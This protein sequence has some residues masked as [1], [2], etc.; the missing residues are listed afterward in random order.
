MKTLNVAEA[1][2]F[3]K[4][5]VTSME[6]LAMDGTVPAAKIGRSWVFIEDQLAE[7]L[8]KQIAD[9]TAER[10]DLLYQ[11]MPTKVKTAIS[12]RRERPKLRGIP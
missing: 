1:A 4:I 3:M 2:A 12:R 10:R 5:A 8:M 11:G 9:Q 6:E 7:Y